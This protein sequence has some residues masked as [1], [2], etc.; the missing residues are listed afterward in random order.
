MESADSDNVILDAELVEAFAGIYL[1]KMYDNP[2]P[3]AQY[4]RE[5]WELYCDMNQELAGAM[6]PRE[7]AK[8]TAF[9]HSFTL[10]V[11]CFRVQDYAV[12][13]SATE[14]LAMDHLG[15]IATQL[16]END[17]LRKDFMIESLPVDARGEV[18]VKFTDGHMARLIAKGSGQKMR[19][20]KWRGKR[21][22]LIIGDDLEEDEQ[23]E[24][25]DRRKKFRRWVNRALIPCKRRGG[26]VR[27]HG[28]ILHED[29]Y[30]ARIRK[31]S[32]WKTLLYKAHAG[33]DDFTDILWPEQ[34]PESRLRSIRQNFIDD[35]D[36]SGYSQEYLNDPFDNSEAYLHKD[37]F[38]PMSEDDYD[39]EKI[40]YAGIDFAISKSDRAN[41][42]SITVGGI[43]QGNLVHIHD[44]RLGRWDTHEII[45]QIFYVYKAH[46]PDII[47]V[48][49]G[50][51]WKTLKPVLMKDMLKLDMFINFVELT[52]VRDKAV[53]G[54]PFQARMRARGVRFDKRAEWYPG[55][56][57][58]C[59]RFT[60]TSDAVADDQFDSTATL[61]IGLSKLAEFTHEDF[62]DDDEYD[63][64]EHDPRKYAGRDSVTGY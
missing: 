60:G 25:I 63:R 9:T 46:R 14:S 37:D 22:G 49:N 47:F 40:S 26:I 62:L 15:D 54:R 19:G 45:E 12:I 34:F 28:T 44:Q 17:D 35:G 10:A 18:I 8:S 50:H 20:L 53:R 27:I 31:N 2:Q 59:L 55:Y 61:F 64:I 29:S 13:T 7:H 41:K 3:T 5:V 52:P 42:T 24:N 11:I 16:R 48:E 1:S 38:I 30:L 57:A 6:A 36:P 39:T 4:H 21:P 33:F 58:E 23:V 56:E 51:I 32:Q 43:D